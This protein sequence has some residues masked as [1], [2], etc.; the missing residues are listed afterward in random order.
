MTES[1]CNG[2]RLAETAVGDKN[3]NAEIDSWAET[4]IG[5]G[6]ENEELA[7]SGE[8]TSVAMASDNEKLRETNEA[9]SAL[10]R[11]LENQ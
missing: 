6:S 1:D 7:V 10:L 8:E 9:L 11:D 4:V 2:A 3:E 5:T